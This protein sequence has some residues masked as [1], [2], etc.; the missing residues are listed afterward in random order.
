MLG[1]VPKLNIDVRACV[2]G[3]A[4]DHG[5]QRP[6]ERTAYEQLGR[7]LNLLRVLAQFN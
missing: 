1:A 5:L 4:Q 7:L 2:L 3:I 6:T